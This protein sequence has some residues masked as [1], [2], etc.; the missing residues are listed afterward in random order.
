MS[1][2]TIDKRRKLPL[3]GRG[4][5]IH[6][7]GFASVHII[8]M[9]FLCSPMSLSPLEHRIFVPETLNRFDFNSHFNVLHCHIVNSL[10][11][12]FSLQVQECPFYTNIIF[13]F[14][15]NNKEEMWNANF[16]TANTDLAVPFLSKDIINGFP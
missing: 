16:L 8:I 9:S 1:T 10:Y 13:L 11:F 3:F 7:D 12:R 5:G 4:P 2:V 6:N 15:T 14:L